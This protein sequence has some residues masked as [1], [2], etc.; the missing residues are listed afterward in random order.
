MGKDEY[1]RT[2]E[3]TFSFVRTIQNEF[4]QY[5]LVDIQFEKKFLDEIF[6]MKL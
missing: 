2:E 1:G 5:G 6:T 4:N 3:E